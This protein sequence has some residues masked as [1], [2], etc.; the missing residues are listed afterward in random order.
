[1]KKLIIGLMTL[2]LTV[3]LSLSAMGTMGSLDDEHPAWELIE[4]VWSPMGKGSPSANARAWSSNK[5]I[6]ACNRTNWPIQVSVHASVAQWIEFSI[7]GTMYTWRVRKPGTYA[8]NSITAVISSNGDVGV[9]FSGFANL[10]GDDGEIPIWYAAADVDNPIEI[11]NW[12]PAPELDGECV[13][14]DTELLHDGYTWKLWNKI[15]VVECD[16]A[17]EYQDDAEI[18]LVLMNAKCWIDE[19]TGN[20]KD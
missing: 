1:M 10:K 6:E 15:E 7:S 19:K 14:E 4:E 17:C 3:G 20:F 13:I 16:S 2:A 18:T 12:I 8:A 11:M 9:S 5:V